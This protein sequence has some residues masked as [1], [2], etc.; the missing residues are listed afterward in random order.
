MLSRITCGQSGVNSC[1]RQGNRVSF[2]LGEE[3]PKRSKFFR[4]Q[5][6]GARAVD[7]PLEML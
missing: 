5:I 6:F 4:Q 3:L 1:P 2:K 7:S